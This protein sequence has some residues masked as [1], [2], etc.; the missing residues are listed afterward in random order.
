M[1]AEVA[2]AMEAV[3]TGMEMIGNH[4]EAQEQAKAEDFNAYISEQRAKNIRRAKDEEIRKIRRN[5]DSMLSTQKAKYAK[6]GVLFEGSP[7]EVMT[8][9]ATQ[10]ELDVANTEYNYET[11]AR[12]QEDEADFR[13]KRAKDIKS[14][15]MM[16][17]FATGAYGGSN[18]AT[19]FYN[20]NQNKKTNS[21][22]TLPV[23]KGF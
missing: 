3:G 15:G 23:Y 2:I 10:F 19:S 8:D 21:K 6:A 11:E 4:K 20:M 12:A 14:A 7:L 18:L 17:A 1:M 9:T 16:N 22:K 5:K 13:R